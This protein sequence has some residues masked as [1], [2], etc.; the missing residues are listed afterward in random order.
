VSELLWTPALRLRELVRGQQL[1]PVE[2]LEAL[3]AQIERV[4]PSVHAF[5]TLEDGERLLAAARSAEQAVMRGDALGPLHGLP[6]SVKDLELTAGLRTTSGSKFFEDFV[7]DIDGPVAQRL[8]QAGAIIF[9][10]TNTPQFGHKDSCDNLLGPPTRNPWNLELTAGG[11]SAGAA[12]AVATGIGLAALGTD[13]AGSVR[14]PASFCG[15]VGYKPSFGRVPYVPLCTDGLS[16]LGVLARTVE[17]AATVAA[18][19]AGP[20]PADPSS[21][22]AHAEDDAGNGASPLRIAWAPTLGET[23][24]SSEIVE[25]CS[26]ALSRLVAAGHTVETIAPPAADPYAALAA[27]LG[28]AEAQ[29][30]DARAAHPIREA[31]RDWGRTLTAADLAAALATKLELTVAYTRVFQDFDVLAGPTVPVPPFAAD[32]PAPAE[33]LEPARDWLRWTP[34]TYVFNLTGQPAVTVPVGLSSDGLPVGLQVASAR[35]RDATALRAAA[36]LEGVS[37]DSQEVG[38]DD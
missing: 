25:L 7:P 23:S 26:D 5:V 32:A 8:R 17:D 24:P 18:G 22:L 20:D 19:M 10:K 12:V 16:H 4:D 27:I 30:A 15:V 2:L 14:V 33:F 36:L 35:G 37:L 11:S 1:S 28:A 29:A 3:L 21:L 34:N 13:G 9:G 38:H 31:V 6:V